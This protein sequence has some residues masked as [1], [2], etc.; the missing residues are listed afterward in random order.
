MLETI[1]QYAREKLLDLGEGARLRSRHLAYFLQFAEEVEP[2]LAGSDQARWFRTLE[3]DHDNF[4][5]AIDWA[6][7]G[8]EVVGGLRLAGALG[9][10][11]FTRSYHREGLARLT[12][13]LSQPEAAEHTPARAKALN[14]AARLAWGQADYATARKLADEGLAIATERHDLLNMAESLDYLG[15]AAAE[16]RKYAEARSLLER[17]VILLREAGRL[18]DYPKAIFGLGIVAIAEGDYDM[19]QHWFEESRPLHIGNVVDSGAATLRMLGH[20]ALHDGDIKKARSLYVGSLAQNQE[21]EDK[22]GVIRCV[23]AL[24]GLIAMEGQLSH[25][26]RLLGAVEALLEAT[27]LQLLFVEQDRFDQNIAIMRARLEKATFD[28]EWAAGRAMTL[29]QA[30]ALALATGTNDVA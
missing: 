17:A 2:K 7:D 9:I 20:I 1:R 27:H 19:A 21:I 4:W 26:T 11:W 6:L 3:T 13:A 15:V 29:E 23:A 12:S 14:A 16:E 10:F 5:V 25:A 8:G 30:V 18:P 28:R 24:A 22:I